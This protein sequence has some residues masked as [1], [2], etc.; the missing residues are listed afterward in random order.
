[1]EGQWKTC[2]VAGGHLAPIKTTSRPPPSSLPPPPPPPPP[3]LFIYLF[4]YLF[5]IIRV[6]IYT[7]VYLQ[8]R[9]KRRWRKREKKKRE[10]ERKEWPFPVSAT[11]CQVKT[12]DIYFWAVIQSRCYWWR[13]GDSAKFPPVNRLGARRRPSCTGPA[14]FRHMARRDEFSNTSFA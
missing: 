5:I 4:I 10:R 13:H 14:E 12:V 3:P 6:R 9:G 2:G 1:M 8:Q 11:Y 7:D